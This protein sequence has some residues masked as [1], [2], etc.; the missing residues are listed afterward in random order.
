[1]YTSGCYYTLFSLCCSGSRVGAGSGRKLHNDGASKPARVGGPPVQGLYDH[2]K[3][4]ARTSTPLYISMTDIVHV[5]CTVH[6]CTCILVLI[7]CTRYSEH[8]ETGQYLGLRA[9][10][11]L[12]RVVGLI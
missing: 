6:T 1:M 11:C 5:Q 12:G 7:Q 8:W 10:C 2:P 4:P 3:S 9:A